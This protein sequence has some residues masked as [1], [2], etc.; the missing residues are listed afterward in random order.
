MLSIIVAFDKNQLIGNDNKMP[1]HYPED[2][3]YF[4][5]VTSGRKVVMGSNTFHSIMGY[6]N[7]PLPNRESI[8][9][10]RK[11]HIHD[12]VKVFNSIDEL[13]KQNYEEEVFIIGGK[14]IYEQ[15]LPYVDRLYITHINNE[16]EGNVYFPVINWNKWEKVKEDNKGE[17]SFC[18][19]ERI[20]K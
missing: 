8:V 9:L 11:N 7:K 20:E 2:L 4:K 19:Y 13:L 3:Q 18:V 15:I 6:L 1:W 10:T 16:F 5:E 14:T 17:L 12:E